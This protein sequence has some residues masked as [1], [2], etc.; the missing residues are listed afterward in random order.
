MSSRVLIVIFD[1]LRPEFVTSE[2]MPNLSAFADRG[3]RFL[4]ARSTFPT[5]TRVNQSAVTT[6][7]MPWRH[8]IVGNKFVA[9][10]LQSEL[11]VNS[12]DDQMLEATF[13]AGPVLKKPNIGQRLTA[14]GKQYAALSAGTPG[15]GRL[16]NWSAEQDGTFR[17]AMRR[18]EAC[19]P[20]GVF[21][22]IVNR[23]GPLP[24]YVLPATDWIT[25]AVSTYLDFVEADLSPDAMLLWLCEPDETFHWKNIGGPEA[26]ET[27]AHADAEFGRILDRLKP[28]IDSGQMHVIALSDH[29]QISLSGTRL[30]LAKQMR[31]AGFS[32]RDQNHPEGEA[33]L[34]LASAGGIWMPGATAGRV[35]ELVE[36]LHYHD[37]CGPL[38]TLEGLAG[39]LPSEVLRLNNDRAPDISLVF[40][41]ND[42]PNVNGI[43]GT[44]LHDAPYPE[45]GG[46]HGGLH[47]REL[48][49]FLA[50]GGAAIRPGNVETQAGNI[51]IL[52]TALYLMGLP[53]PGGIDGRVLSEAMAGGP[54]PMSITAMDHVLTSS[55]TTGPRT[56]LSV[57]DIGRARYLN[58]AWIE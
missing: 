33:I 54:D 31:D 28:D 23:I 13:A 41:S 52:P 5:E 21:E 1:A 56:H 18:P 53:E 26:R 44:T 55:N 34:G 4:N 7:C 49:T 15:G 12:G 39:T 17:L 3:A 58:R 50:L 47:A 11:L 37:W 38:F 40:R 8:G 10:D 36:W 22:R 42:A 2:L 6:G 45:G 43:E 35:T 20:T 32:V 19:H 16:I 29:G 27:M 46:C 51:D 30:D 25:W 14:A 24:D 48:H 9:N 57:S